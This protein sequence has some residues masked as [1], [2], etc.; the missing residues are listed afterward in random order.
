MFYEPSEIIKYLLVV[1]RISFI[2]INK[3]DDVGIDG[4][5]YNLHK[6]FMAEEQISI[7]NIAK[8][9]RCVEHYT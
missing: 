5:F 4:I 7:T 9:I 3:V 2:N 1:L 8:K 6:I